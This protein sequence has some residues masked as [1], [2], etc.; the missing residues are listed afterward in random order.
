MQSALSAMGLVYFSPQKGLVWTTDQWQCSSSVS[1]VFSPEDRDG[2][3]LSSLQM[4]KS[5][6]QNNGP[7]HHR[8]GV[9]NANAPGLGCVH[10]GPESN[11]LT[12]RCSLLEYHHKIRVLK[13]RPAANECECSARARK[14]YFSISSLACFE[15]VRPGRLWITSPDALL[16]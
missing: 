7:V 5:K 14:E 1:S 4:H 11:V 3:T 12:M 9:R 2:R 16:K 15:A 8:A 6:T 13:P 10:D